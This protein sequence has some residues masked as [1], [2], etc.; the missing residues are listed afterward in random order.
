MHTFRQDHVVCV[1]FD[2]AP[3]VRRDRPGQSL[4]GDHS[5]VV[6][7][8]SAHRAQHH[9][10]NSCQSHSLFGAEQNIIM[11]HGTTYRRQTCCIR[12]QLTCRLA[13]GAPTSSIS[14]S[15]HQH[16][17]VCLV[18]AMLM[19]LLFPK[20]EVEERCTA[21]VD[22]MRV[23]STRYP[24]CQLSHSPATQPSSMIFGCGRWCA[25]ATEPINTPAP[26]LD[27]YYTTHRRKV[28]HSSR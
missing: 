17:R 9:H 26:S 2:S 27:L 22:L 10:A 21:M 12:L 19:A 20:S 25:A 11:T 8:P 14:T 16:I 18:S 3:T 13:S 28:R 23:A 5:C 24:G 4:R 7:R 1:G 6:V 15:P